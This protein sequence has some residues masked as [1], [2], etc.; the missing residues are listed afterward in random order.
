MKCFG[1][2]ALLALWACDEGGGHAT[3]D[4][5]VDA[6]PVPL[7]RSPRDAAP[8]SLRDPEADALVDAGPDAAAPHE[9]D[10][11]LP[12][13]CVATPP[14]EALEPAGANPGGP[15]LIAGGRRITPAGPN[16]VV[17]GF[18][19]EALIHPDRGVVYLTSTS[20]DDRRLLVLDLNT[21][22][23]RQDVDR[24]EAFFGLALSADGST[25]YASAG[26]AGRVDRYAVQADGTLMLDGAFETGG[27]PAGLALDADGR[28]LWV[29][30]FDAAVV[31][32]LDTATGE[33]TRRFATGANAW[34]LL[35]LANRQE[36][37]VSSL[38]GDGLS[39]IDLAAGALAAEIPVPTSPAGLVAS[40]DGRRVWVAV[41]GAD[42]VAA[43]D[44]ATRTVSSLGR[45]AG[46]TL[47]DDQGQPLPHSNVNAL[48]YD[49]AR[50]RLYASRGAD[51]AVSV[52]DA[53]TLELLG[54][55]P[56]SWYPTDVALLGD[57]LV[58]AEGKGGGAGPSNGEGAKNVMKGSATFVDLAAL[59]L[60]AATATVAANYL[61][62]RTVFPF[63]CDGS[64][65]IPT[66]PG[67]RSPI[68]HVI[69][70]VK[71]NKTFDCV[72]A[73]LD[74]PR[75]H[76]DPSLLRFGEDITPNAHALAR[77]FSL[78][79]N[80]YT[81]VENSDTGHLLLT[82]GHLTEFVEHTWV[83]QARSGGFQGYQLTAPAVPKIGNFFTHLMEHGISL[84]IYG[85]I[86]GMFTEAAG[87]RGKPSQFSD[88]AY[89][90]GPFY[91]TSVFDENKARYVVGRIQAGELAQFTYLLFPN[92]H[93]EG[94]RAGVPTPESMVADND[95]AL[96]LVVDALSHSPFWAHSV[97][98]VLQDDPQGCEDHVD[99]H[100]SPLL[101]IGPHARHGHLSNV[102]S[103]FFSVFATIEAILG[104]P[105]MGRPDAA[106]APLYDMFALPRD[107]TPYTALPRRVPVAYNPEDAPGGQKSARM[108]FHGPDRNPELYPLLDA[109]RL[110]KMGRITRAE[111]DARIERVH[112]DPA[113]WAL[114]EEEAEEE[115]EAFDEAWADFQAARRAQG[116]PPAPV[117]E[118]AQPR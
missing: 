103:S 37:Y 14:P 36:L 91:N 58:V 115:S 17:P 18:P 40:P 111:A 90:G 24:D 30:L 31:V 118:R 65:P 51:N 12:P 41:S 19:T 77:M 102:H 113:R 79:D 63:E 13:P 23:L 21:Q 104:V 117:P 15:W 67:Q 3:R 98:I 94:T 83:E 42:L 73:D 96:G 97:I 62:P 69:L 46:D 8:D 11:A 99:A 80:F 9:P 64:F 84:R 7:D 76:R 52:L 39:V 93:T 100:R 29:G 110:W 50:N 68:E 72:F 34:D 6:A 5:A 85:E 43:L 16:T 86:V 107:L 10:A 82:G 22:E 114:L 53:D 87:G 81:E 49:P 25:L 56:A 38:Q 54:A 74:D 33:E 105:P 60:E 75:A 66:R 70:I 109:Y 89:P 92:D 47:V 106:A 1:W 28:H 26:S 55:L 112:V 108:N 101:V 59:D 45:V 44:P 78:S 48:A 2:L 4:A 20:N 32:E 61:R 71:E 116:L 35:Y 57:L 95:F 88:A 27:Y